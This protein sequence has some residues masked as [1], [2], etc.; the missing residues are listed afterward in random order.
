MIHSEAVYVRGHRQLPI[1]FPVVQ[2]RSNNE[3]YDCTEESH[4][5]V[6]ETFVDNLQIG[7]HVRWQDRYA[8]EMAR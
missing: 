6:Q 1:K 2:M 3:K 7:M 4:G 5:R 8:C